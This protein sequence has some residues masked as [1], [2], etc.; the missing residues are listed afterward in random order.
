MPP[1]RLDRSVSLIESVATNNLRIPVSRLRVRSD[2]FV[3]MVSQTFSDIFR[4]K[5]LEYPVEFGVTE[6]A[7]GVVLSLFSI[8]AATTVYFIPAVSFY[9]ARSGEIHRLPY[10]NV[11]C[12]F[13]RKLSWVAKNEASLY[14]MDIHRRHARP[15]F[16]RRR[17]Y[18]SCD[19]FRL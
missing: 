5:I 10:Y 7:A 9:A 8:Y 19:P 1:G 6:P 18:A 15:I 3:N 12:F 16:P 11:A 4:V 17:K 14:R 2:I 13:Y